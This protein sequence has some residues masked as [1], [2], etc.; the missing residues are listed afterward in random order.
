MVNTCFQH[1]S[2]AQVHASA[3]LGH[4]TISLHPMQ[5]TLTTQHYCHPPQHA[6]IHC[7]GAIVWHIK[8]CASQSYSTNDSCICLSLWTR[9]SRCSSCNA[10]Y[11]GKVLVLTNS[12][13]L[14]L[15]TI[16]QTLLLTIPL[17]STADMLYAHTCMHT[18]L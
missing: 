3:A 17:K 11:T 2:A 12:G 15:L 4:L 14:V 7:S 16:L 5:R 9:H 10:C 18:K 8:C 13:G 6:S 1:L